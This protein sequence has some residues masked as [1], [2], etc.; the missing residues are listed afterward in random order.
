VTLPSGF[1]LKYADTELRVPQLCERTVT[2][3]STQCHFNCTIYNKA[4]WDFAYHLQRWCK[5]T[6][7]KLKWVSDNYV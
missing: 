2:G 1:C 4:N 3:L 6:Q 7:Q 5:I